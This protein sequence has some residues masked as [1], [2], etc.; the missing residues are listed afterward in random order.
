MKKK[1]DEPFGDFP[2]DERPRLMALSDSVEEVTK[3]LT[4]DDLSQFYFDHV[5]NAKDRALVTH[6]AAALAKLYALDILR[7][8]DE[9]KPAEGQAQV[10]VVAFFMDRYAKEYAASKRPK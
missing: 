5:A 8:I 7:P 6:V 9:D 2:E 1:I 4:L 3:S 10:A